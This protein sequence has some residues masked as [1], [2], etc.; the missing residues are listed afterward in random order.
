MKKGYWCEGIRVFQNIDGELREIL[1][2]DRIN[3]PYIR[4]K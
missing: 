3:L 1:K 4:F 2:L